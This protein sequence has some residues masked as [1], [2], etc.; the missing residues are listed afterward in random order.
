[1]RH[2]F[3]ALAATALF[4]F[5]TA[6]ALAADPTVHQVYEAASAGHY[7]QAQQMMDQ[8]LRDH[9]NSGQAHFVEAELLAKQGRIAAAR[10]ELATA[11]RLEPGLPFAKPA[12]VQEL[13]SVLSG[14]AAHAGSAYAPAPRH[15]SFPFG[16]I[17]LLLVAIAAVAFFMRRRAQPVMQTMPGSMPYNGGYGAGPTYYGNG[18]VG[19]MGGG[20]MGSGILGGLATGAAMGAGVVAGEALV[21]RMLDGNGQ[22]IQGPIPTGG[23]DGVPDQ[24]SYDMGGND[25]GLNDA[26]WDDGSGGGGSDDWS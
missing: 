16:L 22:P 17:A 10:T 18:P 6:A 5:G 20:G 12:A 11:Q 7:D 2:F 8:V 9:P 26:S 23:W 4:A 21:H 13:Q 19:P 24:Q 3:S 14:N 25:F 1:M 15:P